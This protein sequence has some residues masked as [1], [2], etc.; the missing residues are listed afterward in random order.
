MPILQTRSHVR[1]AAAL[2]GQT[3]P[4]LQYRVQ[5]HAKLKITYELIHA[6]LS[7][8]DSRERRIQDHK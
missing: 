1:D 3:A 8:T 2:V 7:E 5:T 6:F 4:I